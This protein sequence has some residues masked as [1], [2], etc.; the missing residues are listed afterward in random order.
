[1]TIVDDNA[2]SRAKLAE[3]K[4]A[5]QQPEGAM[6]E[7]LLAA[8]GLKA[9]GSGHTQRDISQ[10]HPALSG[11]MDLVIRANGEWWHE[12]RPIRRMEL[13]RLFASIMR[14]EDDGE[15][16]L[17]TPVEKWRI[18]VED[19]HFLITGLSVKGSGR[20]QTI[21]FVSNLGE[22]GLIGPAHPLSL[23]RDAG[24][25]ADAGN[26][27]FKPYVGFRHGLKGVMTRAAAYELASFVSFSNENN[28]GQAEPA[29]QAASVTQAEP[30][31]QAG[32]VTQVG[33]VTQAGPVTQVGVWSGGVFWPLGSVAEAEGW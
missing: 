20:D 8:A 1:M 10:W 17:V 6:L 9:G 7:R 28:A 5:D 2:Q 18:L 3:T 14:R 23:A 32:P 27:G 11:E 13:V 19:A 12:A 22:A 29:G 21:G 4:L 33:P 26:T 31:N 24:D 30:V 25:R 16:Y 15:T